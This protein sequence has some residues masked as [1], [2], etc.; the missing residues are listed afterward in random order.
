M[1]FKSPWGFESPLAQYL[2]RSYVNQLGFGGFGQ[3]QFCCSV[4][5]VPGSR[6]GQL[7]DGFGLSV[8][9]CMG[10]EAQSCLNIS[11]PCKLLNRP[12]VNARLYQSANESMSKRMKVNAALH[13]A[14]LHARP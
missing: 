7:R 14:E 9:G 6:P 4:S 2:P 11:M 13:V 8:E 10:V 12:R 1:D 3:L 5:A